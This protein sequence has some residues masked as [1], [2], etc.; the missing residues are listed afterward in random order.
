M[1]VKRQRCLNKFRQELYVLHRRMRRGRVPLRSA[2]IF[3]ALTMRSRSKLMSP[4]AA[5]MGPS[6]ALRV[7][8]MCAFPQHLTL[9]A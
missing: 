6:R 2:W 9:R 3:R 7:T 8:G 4:W 5:V 1:R